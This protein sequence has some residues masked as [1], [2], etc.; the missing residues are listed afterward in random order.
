MR[1]SGVV[2][3]AS[4]AGASVL[5]VFGPGGVGVVQLVG[6]GLAL[7]LAAATVALIA[8]RP[9]TRLVFRLIIAA[10]LVDVV[11]LALA[12]PRLYA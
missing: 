9:P 8:T 11:L 3:A 7:A 4:L 12:G 6:L 1:A 10:A 5:V 2:I